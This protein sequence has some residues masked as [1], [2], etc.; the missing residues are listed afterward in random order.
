MG[1]KSIPINFAIQ[2]YKARSGLA[3]AE[4]VVNM[5]AELTPAE[6]KSQ[7]ALFRTPGVTIWQL[8]D[9][10]NP[11]YGMIVMVNKLYVVCGVDL[12]EIDTNKNFSIVGT[13]GT[14]PGRV[15]MTE[16]GTQV[17]I[18]T[19]SGI[20][21]YYDTN[22][23]LFQQ[24]TS[25]NYKNSNSVTTLDGYTVFTRQESQEFFISA[26]RETQTYA[27]LDF[28]LAEAESDNLVTV[29][30]YN[31]QLILIGTRSTEVWYDT[32]NNTFPFERIDG[33]LIKKGTAAKYSAISD[34]T[35]VYWLGD[36]KVWYRAT[37]YQPERISTHGIERIIN[38]M[39][40]I[41]DCFAFIYVQEGHR[42]L[43]TTY[44]TEGKTLCYDI[45]SGL[46]HERESLNPVNMMP[47]QWLANAHA[48]FAGKEL[49]GDINTGTI[50]EL[51]LDA[52]TEN[53]TTMICKVVSATQFDDYNRDSIGRFTLWM[54]TGV[55]LDGI[56]QGVDPQIMMKSSRDGGQIFSN[57]LW[58][59][60]GPLGLYET[61][62]WWDQVEWGRSLI[63]EV[64]VSD[65]VRFAITGA[66][67]NIE[68]GLS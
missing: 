12:Y 43:C 63:L 62:V 47:G 7:V 5:Y 58:Q 51:D 17:T 23:M 37:N 40:V 9:N 68:Q 46:W 10:F 55:G 14:A 66:F 19:Q 64:S 42:F 29:L 41:G 1:H 48:N 33:V 15:M 52:Y 18:L 27:A 38:E 39:E 2:S 24:I 26:I 20:A 32:G 67:I 25:P 35:G 59:P 4:R 53:E 6:S 22:T 3:S 50:Y 11:I 49:V 65:P 13:L 16:N 56:P 30:N 45:T 36:D 21:Y 60:M 28:A 61:E 54:D 34:V 44:P 57:E 8:L 31:R